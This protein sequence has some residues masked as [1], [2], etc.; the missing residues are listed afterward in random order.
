MTQFIA[1][2]LIRAGQIVYLDGESGCVKTYVAGE[3]PFA[4]ALRDYAK[5]DATSIPVPQTTPFE[6][7]DQ[8]NSGQEWLDGLWREI[9]LMTQ[10]EKIHLAT[11]LAKV[12]DVTS[13]FGED[14]MEIVLE[15]DTFPSPRFEM[16]VPNTDMIE[17]GDIVSIT[18]EWDEAENQKKLD[19]EGTHVV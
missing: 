4:V 9:A 3:E 15:N 12:I 7:S 13:F 10:G 14:D 11:I 1:G 8:A 5:G 18:I 17:I 6:D 2:E 16:T 19:T